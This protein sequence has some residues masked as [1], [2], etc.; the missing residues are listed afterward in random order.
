MTSAWLELLI[1]MQ[2]LMFSLLIS[3]VNSQRLIFSLISNL[4]SWTVMHFSVFNSLTFRSFVLTSTRLSY[5]TILSFSLTLIPLGLP[6]SH[7]CVHT[8]PFY[9]SPSLH[10]NSCE[11]AFSCIPSSQETI[12]LML[13]QSQLTIFRVMLNCLIQ[14]I[15]PLYIFL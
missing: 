14:T 10:H 13:H 5:L 12:L 4:D 8:S 3:D 11:A 9:P 6:I 15:T 7:Q 2:I 1:S